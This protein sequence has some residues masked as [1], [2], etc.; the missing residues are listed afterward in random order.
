VNENEKRILTLL[1]HDG[2]RTRKEIAAA[3]DL[4]W[5]AV[6]KLVGRLERKGLVRCVGQNGKRTENGKTALHYGPAV[7]KPL[8]LAIDVEYKTTQVAVYN[9]QR[10]RLYSESLPTPRVAD[11]DDFIAFVRTVVAKSRSEL[12]QLGLEIDGIGLGMPN[13]LVKTE[14]PVFDEVSHQL[15]SDFGLPVVADNNSR[16]YTLYLQRRYGFG[17]SFAAVIVRT[18]IGIGIALDSRLYRGEDGLAGELGH[19]TVDPS[20]ARCRC[21]KRGCVE[22]YFN[23]NVLAKKWSQ[24]RRKRMPM[25]GAAGGLMLADLFSEAKKGNPVAVGV[26]EET[27]RSLSLCVSSLLLTLDLRR[28]IV[29]GHFG[30][31]GQIL[32]E[33]ITRSL[34]TALHPRLRFEL[35]YDPIHDEGFGIGASMLFLSS[36]CDFSVLDK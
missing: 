11:L 10:D 4:S 35:A 18:G 28:I 15:A 6:V 30:P 5:A 13:W 19:L 1:I 3:C 14:R 24:A 8:A 17:G 12:K 32:T 29:T 23:E 20:G 31:H 7:D 33:L 26:L 27:G 21:G 16:A 2:P 22:T 34:R 25:G 9:I 36:Y